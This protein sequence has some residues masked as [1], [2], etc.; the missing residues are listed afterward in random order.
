MSETPRRD[1]E[2]RYREGTPP[3]DIGRPQPEIVRLAEEGEIVGDVLDVGCGTGENALH[4]ASIGHRVLGVDA[5]PTAILQAQEKAAARA[6]P[7]QF[8]VADA[9]HLETLRRR[10]ETAID[11]GLFHVFEREERRAYAE[12]LTEVLSPGS[13][14]HVLCFSDEEPPGYGPKRISEYEIRDAFRG[15]F[16]PTRIRPALFEHRFEG[17]P[18]KAWLATL[19]KI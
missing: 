9:K 10:F 15:I 11:C 5:S 8:R 7:A 18:A 4:L 14:L 12:S 16:A 13:T 6:L 19:V 17:G 1:F 3:W 2:S